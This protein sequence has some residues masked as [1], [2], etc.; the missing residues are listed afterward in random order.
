MVAVGITTAHLVLRRR[1]QGCFH[2]EDEH[3]D[4]QSEGVPDQGLVAEQVETRGE[5]RR[6]ELD[7]EEQQG[8][9]HGDQGDDPASD[10]EQQIR[11]S[12]GVDLWPCVDFGGQDGGP[13]RSGG[14]GELDQP[15]PQP[16]ASAEAANEPLPGRNLATGQEGGRLTHV[17]PGSGRWAGRDVD[18]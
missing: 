4:E 13:G 7:G 6:G 12:G 17:G 18:A 1:A 11:R 9:D 10:G 16:W 14:V 15:G 8:E 5:R 2:C 3:S